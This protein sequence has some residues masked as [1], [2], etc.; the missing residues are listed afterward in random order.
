MNAQPYEPEPVMDMSSMPIERP[1][2]ILDDGLDDILD[3][4]EFGPITNER[5]DTTRDLAG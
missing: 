3:I 5:S 2:E 1:A 4:P